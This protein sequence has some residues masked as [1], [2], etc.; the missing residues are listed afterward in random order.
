MS[1]S[2]AVCGATGTIRSAVLIHLL[3]ARLLKAVDRLVLLGHGPKASRARR[4]AMRVDLLDAFDDE[5][6][7][8]EVANAVEEVRADTVIK[9]CR[10]NCL[11]AAQDPPRPCRCE[12][13]DPRRYGM[14]PRFGL[15]SDRSDIAASQDQGRTL[16]CGCAAALDARRHRPC[17]A[18]LRRDADRGRRAQAAR[19]VD[20]RR[21]V[22]RPRR[23]P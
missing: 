20:S 1:V 5:E 13:A 16:H 14:P 10:Q 11:S 2:V 19:A 4:M 8:I 9:G 6:V 21:A 7:D 3:T 17:D 15:P 18:R 12:R 22:L 23:S